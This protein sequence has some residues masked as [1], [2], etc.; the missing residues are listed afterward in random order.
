MTLPS[1]PSSISFNDISQELFNNCC[2]FSINDQYGR[3]VACVPT[4]NTTISLSNFYGKSAPI[5]T[6]ATCCCGGW[7]MGCTTACG[8]NYYLI[9]SPATPGYQNDY[10]RTGCSVC[11]NIPLMG[12]APLGTNPSA[13]DDGYCITKFIQTCPNYSQP[14]PVVLPVVGWPLINKIYSLSINGFSDW[15]MPA[16]NEL[17]TMFC[18]TDQAWKCGG[19]M[20]S[21]GNQFT[22]CAV[23]TNLPT[24]APG[25][26]PYIGYTCTIAQTPSPVA[27]L[28][29]F[30][31]NNPWYPGPGATCGFIYPAHAG[32]SPLQCQISATQA[33]GN[34]YLAA[35]GTCS[36]PGIDWQG[37]FLCAPTGWPAPPRWTLGQKCL[38]V[39]T[40][41]VRRVAF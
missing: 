37:R 2:A 21:T 18:N 29:A 16:V 10:F 14:S 35:N 41:A 1:A 12:N 5:S 28:L 3:C 32:L 7:Y 26:W 11:A 25:C 15:Y 33:S 20:K 23:L 31:C 36:Q 8:V 6:L 9:A 34:P 13:A 38:V 4:P 22:I 17:V 24:T 19:C 27:C 40:R 39:G 30:I